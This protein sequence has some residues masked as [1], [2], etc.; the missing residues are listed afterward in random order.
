MK[1]TQ[2]KLGLHRAMLAVF[3]GSAL[4]LSASAVSAASVTGVL[5]G[6]DCASKGEQCPTSKDD[7]HLSYEADFVVQTSSGQFFF[8]PN[9]RQAVKVRYA[10]DMVRVD[11]KKHAKFDSIQADSMHVKRGNKY[12]QVWNSEWSMENA[13]KYW[14]SGA[15]Q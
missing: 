4:L 7:P 2:F 15:N 10:T 1:H 9:I 12:V 13:Q 5:N 3:A 8:V 11:G 6:V 14:K